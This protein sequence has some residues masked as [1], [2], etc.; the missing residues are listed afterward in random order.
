VPAVYKEIR[1]ESDRFA[2][3]TWAKKINN[4]YGFPEKYYKNKRKLKV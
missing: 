3:R 4:N 2:V 1:E